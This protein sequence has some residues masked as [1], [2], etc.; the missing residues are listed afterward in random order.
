MDVSV[1][2]PVY[3]VAPYVRECLESL[4]SQTFDGDM[5]C[6]I[7]DDCGT[8][9][10]MGIVEEMIAEYSGN[11]KFVVL[12]HEHNR[13]L[14]AARNT[15]L[16]KAEGEYVF[17]L[18]SDD[19]IS[20]DCIQLLHSKAKEH[21]KCVMVQAGTDTIPANAPNPFKRNF[22]Q[23]CAIS[24][25][26]VRLCFFVRRTMSESAWNNLVNRQF[27]T[28]ND[29][30]FKEGRL[31]EDQL[32]MFFVLKH[33]EFVCFINKITYHYRRRDDSIAYN[34]EHEPRT[35]FI[36]AIGD[37]YHD[38]LTNLTQNKEKQELKYYISSFSYFYVR[39][40]REIPV[41]EEDYKLYHMSAKTHRCHMVKTKLAISHFLGKYKK[42]WW[43]LMMLKLIRH[44]VS[45]SKRAWIFWNSGN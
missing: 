20:N 31:A 43:I 27:L 32:W 3:N 25:D 18:D 38:Y 8:D 2:I 7:V 42:G 16:D 37:N 1:I 39:Y 17:F 9:D 45:V 40:V 41:F 29:L 4:I 21:P 15:G 24:N 5:E 22:K 13:G 44:P 26:E 11:I 6:I 10:S 14:S 35:K 23:G 34:L 30:Y 28:D 36:G 19:T 33:A 12:R